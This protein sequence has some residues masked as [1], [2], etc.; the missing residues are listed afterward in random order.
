MTAATINAYN[1]VTKY[2]QGP[3]TGRKSFESIENLGNQ[4]TKPIKDDMDL[5]MENSEIISNMIVKAHKGFIEEFVKTYSDQVGSGKTIISKQEFQD[6][7]NEW[8]AKQPVEKQREI[9]NLDKEITKIV[10]ATRK[11]ININPDA[12]DPINKNDAS[13][14]YSIF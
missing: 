6:Q 11:G 5:Y 10:E 4:Y 3:N 14:P 8:K 7:L 2:G 1:A 13:D 9:E 12:N